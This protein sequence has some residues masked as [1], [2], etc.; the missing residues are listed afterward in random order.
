MIVTIAFGRTPKT[1]ELVGEVK[2]VEIS[3][4][5]RVDNILKGQRADKHSISRVLRVESKANL[6]RN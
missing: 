2:G 6:G 1:A 4:V 3:V 5:Q